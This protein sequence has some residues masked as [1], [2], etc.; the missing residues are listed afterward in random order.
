[1]K[2]EILKNKRFNEVYKLYRTKLNLKDNAKVFEYFLCDLLLIG[3]DKN[4]IRELNLTGF[5]KTF[6]TV[7]KE[8]YEICVYFKVLYKNESTSDTG[9]AILITYD[10]YLGLGINQKLNKLESWINKHF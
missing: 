7:R 8:L 6:G 9:R 5:N 2:E 3:F 4:N 10:E 1:M